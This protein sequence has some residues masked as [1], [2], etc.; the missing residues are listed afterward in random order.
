[1]RFS[2]WSSADGKEFTLWEGDERPGAE[3]WTE[4]EGVWLVHRFEAENWTAAGAEYDRWAANLPA[5]AVWFGP[6]ESEKVEVS[7]GQ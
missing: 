2:V 3:L 4:P 5:D 1:M 7:S 6:M